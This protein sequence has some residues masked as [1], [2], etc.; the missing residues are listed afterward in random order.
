MVGARRALGLTQRQL[1]YFLSCHPELEPPRFSR[2]RCFSVEHVEKIRSAYAEHVKKS[3][4]RYPRGVASSAPA[5]SSIVLPTIHL[6]GTPKSH[7][8]EGLEPALRAAYELASALQAM[9]PN[10]RDYYPQGEGAFYKA[11]TEHA[12][13]REALEK[14]IKDLE[15]QVEHVSNH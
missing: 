4:K 11:A 13:R 1:E 14:I 9:S 2:Q 7:L 5:A 3:P 6:N 15:E 8:L 10:A 12:A